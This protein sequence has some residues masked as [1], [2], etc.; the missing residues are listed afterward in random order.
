MLA[1]EFS[2]L[3]AVHKAILLERH[4]VLVSQRFHQ[5]GTVILYWLKNF[6]VEAYF[7]KSNKLE[8]IEAMT[9]K[10]P[11]MFYSSGDKAYVAG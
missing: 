11:T 6:F 7:S 2:P 9:V 4:G 5:T 3:S 8:R 10:A 1:Q